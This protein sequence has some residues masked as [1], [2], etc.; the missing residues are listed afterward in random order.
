MTPGQLPSLLRSLRQL[1]DPA[2]PTVLGDGAL[3]ARFV[4]DGDEDAFTELVRR[5]GP[6]V[7]GVCR[8]VLGSWHEAEDAFQTT[9]LLL[10][11][12][13]GQLRSPTRWGRGCMVWPTGPL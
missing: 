7:L 12:K 3:L 2:G 6:M 11:R 10:V 1:S 8:R 4:R 13:A 5:H 9:F